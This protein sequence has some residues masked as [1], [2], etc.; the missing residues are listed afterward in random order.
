MWKR[1]CKYIY[2]KCLIN[3][4]RKTEGVLCIDVSC[5]VLVRHDKTRYNTT[6]AEVIYTSLIHANRV[7]IWRSAV[8]FVYVLPY[9]TGVPHSSATD[10]QIATQ[11][12]PPIEG[13]LA[14]RWPAQLSP[15]P[16]L[17]GRTKGWHKHTKRLSH[18]QA[19]F[20][21]VSWKIIYFGDKRTNSST[22]ILYYSNAYWWHI[23]F[24]TIR[25]KAWELCMSDSGVL[26]FTDASWAFMYFTMQHYEVR[27]AADQWHSLWN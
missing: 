21:R 8:L 12:P 5:I 2:I 6:L 13:V 11:Q 25:Y 24:S 26:S 17:N 14:A 27:A 18:K 1:P 19:P 23:L 3:I 16:T 20:I 9:I 7:V 4:A 10:G 15:P 22:S